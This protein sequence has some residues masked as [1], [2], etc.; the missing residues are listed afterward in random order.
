[1]K[2]FSHS[3]KQQGSISLWRYTENERNFR[4]WH[5][6]ADESGCRSLVD[7]IE[8]LAADGAPASRSIELIAP[9][10]AI[11]GVPNNRGGT[12][13]Y[14]SPQKWRVRFSSEPDH[15]SFPKQL[16]PAEF[17]FGYEWLEPL[18]KGISG[19]SQGLGDYSIGSDLPL[20]FW[21]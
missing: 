16:D 17:C 9:T 12:A 14:K 7:L 15:W 20:W 5:L 6:S 21:W 4:G 18:R 1:M 19:M 2:Q 3:W 13:S 11:L 8:A 10:P